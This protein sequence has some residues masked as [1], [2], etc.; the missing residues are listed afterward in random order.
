MPTYHTE[1]RITHFNHRYALTFRI[2]HSTFYF[3]NY[4]IPHFTNSPTY[5][6]YHTFWPAP[7]SSILLDPSA[8]A[9]RRIRQIF[10]RRHKSAKKNSASAV[11]RQILMKL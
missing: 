8:A 10:V 5:A 4:A 7:V 6:P 1:F 11:I 3:T 9:N 2:F